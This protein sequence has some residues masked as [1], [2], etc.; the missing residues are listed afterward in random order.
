LTSGEA[1]AAVRVDLDSVD[2][3]LETVRAADGA[4]GVGDLHSVVLLEIG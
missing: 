4:E 2:L 1:V 3:G